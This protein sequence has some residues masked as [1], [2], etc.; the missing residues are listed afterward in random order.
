[1]LREECEGARAVLG[2]GKV[3]AVFPPSPL[4][5]RAGEGGRADLSEIRSRLNWIERDQR[6]RLRSPIEDSAAIAVLA[7]KVKPPSAVPPG[8]EP[9]GFARLDGVDGPTSTASKCQSVAAGAP[10]EGDRP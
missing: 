4:W 2:I 1:M 7:V 8:Q 5:G 9:G 10:Q 3:G 6:S